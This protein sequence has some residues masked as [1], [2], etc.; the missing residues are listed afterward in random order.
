MIIGDTSN[1]R[2]L[3]LSADAA[4]TSSK[5]FIPPLLLN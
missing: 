5:H 3:S 2:H 4:S 1:C